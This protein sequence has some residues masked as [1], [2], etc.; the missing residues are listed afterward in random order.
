MPP[1]LAPLAL[2]VLSSPKG[3]KP[4]G[5]PRANVRGAQ[6]RGA[7]AKGTPDPLVA[8]VKRLVSNLWPALLFCDL[9]TPC[10][11]KNAWFCSQ[12]APT[13][14]IAALPLRARCFHGAAHAGR[15]VVEPGGGNPVGGGAK[16]GR[17]GRCRPGRHRL[18]RPIA[19]EISAK[20]SVADRSTP[21]ATLNFLRLWV[22]SPRIGL[23]KTVPWRQG[24][25]NLQP[26]IEARVWTGST[27]C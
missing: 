21:I 2:L 26:P 19:Q 11:A 13:F 3:A 12:V 20:L 10:R 16:A 24:E 17:V 5:L 23:P 4:K 15:V 27:T 25:R 1:L 14:S 7:L 18:R 22:V 9:A 8:K 6:S